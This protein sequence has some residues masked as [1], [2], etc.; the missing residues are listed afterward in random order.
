MSFE[1]LDV[2]KRSKNLS[3][4]I[5]RY[6]T[7]LDDW[8]FKDQVTR[9]S[10]SILSNIAEGMERASDKEKAR[11][12]DIAKASSAELRT[13]II[14]WIEAGYRQEDIG[15]KWQNETK[16]ISA[17][18]VGLSR[19]LK[20]YDWSLSTSLFT[21]G[22]DLLTWVLPTANWQ[23]ITWENENGAGIVKG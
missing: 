18:L 16:E 6:T 20:P 15:E 10:L 23:L 21:D 2:W 13:Q 5:N 12:L 7:K 1:S 8:G 4:E 11:F 3:V 22:L 19:S 9:S 17:M 14:I